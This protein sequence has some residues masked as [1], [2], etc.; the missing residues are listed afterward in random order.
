MKQ[1]A[2]LLELW[3]GKEERRRRRRYIDDW[4]LLIVLTCTVIY[5]AITIYALSLHLSDMYR[6]LKQDNRTNRAHGT[7]P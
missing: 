2:G 3:R 5:P 6:E 4:W 1:K 7:I